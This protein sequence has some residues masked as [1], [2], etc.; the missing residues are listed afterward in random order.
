MQL[1]GKWSLDPTRLETMMVKPAQGVIGQAP[2][3]WR[4]ERLRRA[5]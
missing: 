4:P 1:A 5:G 2:I 3:R